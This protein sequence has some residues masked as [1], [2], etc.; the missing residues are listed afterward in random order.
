MTKSKDTENSFGPM[1][2]ATRVTGKAANSTAKVFT[3][4]VRATRNTV[5]GRT[6]NASAGSARK[7][8]SETN[9]SS[10]LEAL[11]K[12]PFLY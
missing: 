11:Y 8:L 3:L 1:V 7:A 10:S 12:R 2:A 9:S 4:Q 5:S 6:V